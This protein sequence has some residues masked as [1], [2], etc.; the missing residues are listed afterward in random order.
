MEKT[1]KSKFGMFLSFGLT[2]LI[3]VLVLKLL[4]WIPASFQKEDIKKYKTVE[5]VNEKLKISR[6]YVPSYFPDHIKWPPIEIFAQKRPFIL[7]MMH[8]AHVDSGEYA[9]SIYQADS[10]AQFEPK[11]DILYIKDERIV[12]VKDRQAKIQLAVCRGNIKCNSLSWEEGKFRL[13]LIGDDTPEQLLKMAES[14]LQ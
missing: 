4:N 2:V 1:I 14:M 9:L 8:F 12:S 10:G 7:I 13:F 11:R 3:A 6:V 5:E